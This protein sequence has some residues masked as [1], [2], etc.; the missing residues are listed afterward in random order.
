MNNNFLSIQTWN[1]KSTLLTLWSFQG[2]QLR[3]TRPPAEKPVFKQLSTPI[4]KAQFSTF[5]G[6]LIQL[7]T[8]CAMNHW[9]DHLKPDTFNLDNFSD[10]VLEQPHKQYRQVKMPKGSYTL[11]KVLKNKHL[12]FF[13]KKTQAAVTPSKCRKCTGTEIR[14]ELVSW[15]FRHLGWNTCQINR[16]N[17]PNV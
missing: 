15:F 1:K 3:N 5:S 2:M 9:N 6:L 10:P 17:L 13:Q 4:L 8:S 16:N 12:L 14:L 7:F 11:D